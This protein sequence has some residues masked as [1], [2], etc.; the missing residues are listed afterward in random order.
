MLKRRGAVYCLDAAST[1]FAL[2]VYLGVALEWHPQ[3]T[4]QIILPPGVTAAHAFQIRYLVPIIR[5]REAESRNSFLCSCPT[6]PV[7]HIALFGKG[8]GISTA[9][10]FLFMLR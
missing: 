2:L 3:H 10:Q 6:N 9:P 8:L 7:H 4:T 5:E 1:L